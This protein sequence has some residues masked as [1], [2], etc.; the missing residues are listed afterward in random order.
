MKL[1]ASVLC[2][3]QRTR[4]RL[5]PLWPFAL[6]TVA[7]L[8]HGLPS[9]CALAL[10]AQVLQ[11]LSGPGE[12]QLASFAAPGDSLSALQETELRFR[13]FSAE[14]QVRR[15]SRAGETGGPEERV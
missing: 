10:F 5:A 12:E 7:P 6:A 14:V 2:I 11:W 9:P 13:A 4:Q 8:R 3:G 15:G 1:S